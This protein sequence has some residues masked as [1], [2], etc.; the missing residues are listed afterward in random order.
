MEILLNK[1]FEIDNLIMHEGKFSVN[2]L[3][4][5]LDNITNVNRE[6]LVNNGDIIISTTKSVSLVNGEQ[7]MDVVLMLP[8]NDSVCTIEPYEFKRKFKLVNALYTKIEDPSLLQESLNFINEYITN[9]K[10]Q[11]ITSAYL[12][13]KKQG[14]IEIYVSINPNII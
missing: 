10:L 9:N 3:Q 4:S 11:P 5:A 7:V 13:Q 1:S 8:V 14:G 12:V 2:E 6:H